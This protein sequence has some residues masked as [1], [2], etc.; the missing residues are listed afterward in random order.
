MQVDELD[1]G[2]LQPDAGTDGG[3]DAGQ[4]LTPDE[5][6]QLSEAFNF[7]LGLAAGDLEATRGVLW[8]RYDGASPLRLRVWRME[9]D[10]YA[11]RVADA[12][13]T[14]GDGGFVHLETETIE[15]V[16]WVSGDHHF[17]SVGFVSAMGVGRN[18]LDPMPKVARLAFIN[19]S[20]V[21]L[22][23]KDSTL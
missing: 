1:G 3:V 5:P 17:A 20:G 9:A 19:G 13:V 4:P 7:P 23:A 21:E 18:A 6:E 2:L 22:F 11:E 12:V 15:G 8:T 10:V 14:P 16:L